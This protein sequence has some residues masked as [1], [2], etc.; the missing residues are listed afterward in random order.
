MSAETTVYVLRTKEV[1][2][3]V[4]VS[5]LTLINACAKVEEMPDTVNVIA[6]R[7]DKAELEFE[8]LPPEETGI[9]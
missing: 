1:I 7:Y 9:Y 8:Y 3:I 6:A 5:A 4:E 2:E